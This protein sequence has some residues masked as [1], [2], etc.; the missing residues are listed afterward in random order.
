MLALN[1]STAA[2]NPQ[3]SRLTPAPAWFTLAD[4]QLDAY[5]ARVGLDSTFNAASKPPATLETLST[6]IK[7]HQLAIPFE[8]ITRRMLVGDQFEIKVDGN[9]IFHKLVERKRGG[10]CFEQN[11]LMRA[12]LASIGF[13]VFVISG[14]VTLESFPLVIQSRG[15]NEEAVMTEIDGALDGVAIAS[16]GYAHIA[17]LILI[18]Q[19]TYFVDVG[20][21]RGQP[22]VPV[23]LD[24]SGRSKVITGF[25]GEQCVIR[26]IRRADAASFLNEPLLAFLARSPQPKN[27]VAEN[28]AK[29]GPLVFNGRSNSVSD[30]ELRTVFSTTEVYPND[31]TIPAF[32]VSRSQDNF[33][34]KASF[35]Y[36]ATPAGF[37][38]NY[39]ARFTIREYDADNNETMTVAT[40]ETAE[41]LAALYKKYFGIVLSADEMEYLG[42]HMDWFNG[43]H[44]TS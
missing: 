15:N 39:F 38:S 20:F 26:P 27:A 1:T 40:G 31:I 6:V 22:S 3:N 34:N 36:I 28:T 13:R 33:F 37:V 43:E 11:S 19:S 17:L 44:Y 8:N 4:T 2:K 21:G 42:K 16:G 29:D 25:F 24:P 30:W 23:L 5:F 10:V 9:S 14:R 35:G 32:Y 7:A 18:D 12:V 41:E